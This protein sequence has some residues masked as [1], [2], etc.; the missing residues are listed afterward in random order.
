MA[1][2]EAQARG[3]TLYTNPTFNYSRKSAGLTEF[4]QL[5]QSLPVTGRIKLLREAGAASV[6]AAESDGAFDL[7]QARSALRAAFYRVLAVLERQAAYSST[8]MEIDKVVT[9]LR[10]REREGEGSRFDRLRTERERAELLAEK[11]LLEANNELER[12]RLLAFLPADLTPAPLAGRL[13]PPVV[14]LDSTDLL[15][16]ASAARADIR[17]EQQRLEQ[18]RAEVRA[19]ERLRIPEPVVSAGLKRAETGLNRIEQRLQVG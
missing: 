12:A 9:V 2:A 15:K 7:W 19:A 10:D 5:E 8:L 11:A 17:A 4:F 3:R 18:Y 13:E 6:R 14:P 16:R 1:I